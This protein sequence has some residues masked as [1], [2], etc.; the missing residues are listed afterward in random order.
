MSTTIADCPFRV[1]RGLGVFSYSLD[2]LA[3][4]QGH[5]QPH[6]LLKH[7]LNAIYQFRSDL[8][9][10]TPDIDLTRHAQEI[11]IFAFDVQLQYFQLLDK[12]PGVFPPG[13]T[14]IPPSAALC[15]IGREDRS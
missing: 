4:E 3:F 10:I 2:A 13:I 1:L 12:S 9:F 14:T 15:R 11:I 6:G 8:V 7:Q 5:Q